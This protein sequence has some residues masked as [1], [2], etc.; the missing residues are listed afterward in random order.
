MQIFKYP[1]VLITIFICGFALLAAIG[2]YFAVKG[3]K[4][5]E[6]TA[7][8]SFT[9]ISKMEGC[10]KK[11]G[12]QR[13][14]RCLMYISVSFDNH[15][16]SYEQS[17]ILSEI[18]HILL[19]TFLDG[20]NSAISI[21]DNKN[22]VVLA[23]W[24]AEKAK[25]IAEACQSELNK[26]LLNHSALNIVNIRIGSYCA[27]GTQVTFDEAISRAKQACI[28][29][30]NEK[31]FYAEWDIG[32]GKALEQ[33][34]KI[35]NN[36]EKEIDNNR[37]FLEYQPVLDA[38]TGKIIGAEVLSRL[39]SETDG[40]LT[41]RNFLSAVESV[42]LNDKFDYYIFEKNCKW[43]SNDKQQR[44][45]Y[46]YT[47]NFSRSTLSEPAF[48]EKIISI[49]EKYELK[50]SCL[51]VEILEDKNITGEAK[52]Q[53]IDNLSTL[54]GKGV[55]ILLD[56]FGS[57]YTTFGDLQNLDI[58]I[59]KIDKAITQNAV[60]DTGFIILKNIIQTS[61]D[62]GFK[63]L[64]EGVETKE[65]EEAVIRAGCDLIQ[66]FYYYKPMPVSMLE[67]LFNQ[68]RGQ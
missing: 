30:K 6:G 43:I 42:G 46:K 2:I 14:D 53:M 23:N 35:E 3:I 38:K 9:T 21:Y 22:F 32:S 28:L 18:K 61:K 56:D 51:A 11:A 63:T 39:N 17:N 59:V 34:I 54:K 37:F 57:G 52:Q 7:E 50:L 68:S 26:C 48:V 67:K 41:P 44:E 19:N 20:E 12:K 66:G 49:A 15:F 10:F 60:T 13:E 65:Q 40:V 62:I 1:Y 33:K 24:S 25:A 8:N 55:S 58:S 64:C 16:D 47:I 45:G 4:T 5:A 29:A 27:V 31:L 36:I